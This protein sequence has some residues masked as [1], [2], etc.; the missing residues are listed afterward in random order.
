VSVIIRD[1]AFRL[2]RPKKLVDFLKK[3]GP[4]VAPSANPEGLKPA[5]NITQAKKYFGSNVNF[6]LAG[7][8]LKSEPS[9]L[10]EINKKVK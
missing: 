6:Y 9:V 5:E 10:I 1:T 7:K 3:T 4:L 8:T 2:P